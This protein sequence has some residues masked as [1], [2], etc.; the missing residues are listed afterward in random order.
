M[1]DVVVLVIRIML[2]YARP[3]LRQSHARKLLSRC[4]MMVHL[5]QCMQDMRELSDSSAACKLML[6]AESGSQAA[7]EAA[8]AACMAIAGGCYVSCGP[9]VCW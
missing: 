7:T 5:R 1:S 8:T 9:G 3:L 2:V 4:T 6:S